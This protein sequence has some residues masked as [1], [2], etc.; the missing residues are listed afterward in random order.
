MNFDPRSLVLGAQMLLVAFGALVLVPLLTG[1]DPAVALMTA[2]IGTL[3]FQLVTKRRVPIFLASSFAFIAPIIHGTQTWGV[4]AT[5]GSLF[6][7]GMVYVAVA[8]VVRWRGVE[9]LHR[10]FP[11]IVVG[12]VVMLIGLI[13]APVAVNMALGKTG[14]G[15]QIL[16]PSS[17]SL[18]VASLALAATV[19]VT[20]FAKGFWRMLAVLVGILLGFMAAI[21]FGMIDTSLWHEAAWFG[22]PVFTFPSFQWEAILFIVPVTLVPIIEHFGDI[23]AV[24]SVTN[25]DYVQSPGVHKTLLGDGLATM[26]AAAIGGPPNTTYS[27]VTG[28]VALTRSFDPKI[29]TWAAVTAI[30]LAFVAK[31]GALLKMVPTPVMGGILILLF[32]TIVV[33]GIHQLVQ[34]R[35]DLMQRRNLVIVGV[36]MTCGVGGMNIELGP[37]AIQGLGLASVLGVLLNQL[38]PAEQHSGD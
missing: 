5:L 7:A 18:I 8:A 1:L 35:T 27:E 15:S 25:E 3:I 14:D 20:L 29:M 32:G 4:E 24:G 34:A 37:W 33:V 28:A 9:I 22:V 23:L 11:P 17:N 21:P 26:F 6:V 30:C 19:G 31:L 16:F 13:L 36:M 12:P 38:L 10:L 2:G